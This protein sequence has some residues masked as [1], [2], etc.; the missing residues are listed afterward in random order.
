[1]P[2]LY[3]PPTWRN[4]ARICGSL[5]F[6]ITTSTCT[7]RLGGQWFNTAQPGV[8]EL[9]DADYVFTRPTPVAAD[10]AAELI[11]YGIGTVTEVP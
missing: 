9:D 3:T 10:I 7:Y 4:V 2:F 6:G 1:M 11:A 8:G 5:T